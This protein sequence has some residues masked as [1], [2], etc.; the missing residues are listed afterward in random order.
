M[1]IELRLTFTILAEWSSLYVRLSR[2]IFM[3]TLH[4]MCS[5]GHL[6]NVMTNT[7]L[8]MDRFRLRVQDHVQ[9]TPAHSAPLSSQVRL[10]EAPPSLVMASSGSASTSTLVPPA[11]SA[12]S[13]ERVQY[14]RKVRGFA[15]QEVNKLYSQVRMAPRMAQTDREKE[16]E[17]TGCL[18]TFP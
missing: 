11:A 16:R 18:P 7:S 4:E 17:L 6:T 8:N 9:T 2:E 3:P 10:I 13:G 15:E 12:L 5:F 14:L 1:A